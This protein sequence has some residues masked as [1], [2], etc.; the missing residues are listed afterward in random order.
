MVLLS[1]NHCSR[2]DRQTFPEKHFCIVNCL[3]LPV[4]L[5]REGLVWIGL[6]S[7][8]TKDLISR[9]LTLLRWTI[10][11]QG[12][13]ITEFSLEGWFAHRFLTEDWEETGFLSVQGIQ[14][15]PNVQRLS[16]YLSPITKLLSLLKEILHKHS[17]KRWSLKIQTE[18]KLKFKNMP[19]NAI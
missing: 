13:K 5:N 10:C 1:R 9:V 2:A 12:C 16:F 3:R 6:W 11:L 4:V 14:A 19:V 8:W 18:R 15:V 7:I 17:R